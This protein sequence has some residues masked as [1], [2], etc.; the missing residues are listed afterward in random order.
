ML[1]QHPPFDAQTDPRTGNEV[2]PNK[3]RLNAAQKERRRALIVPRQRGAWGMLL[4]LVCEHF[5][6]ALAA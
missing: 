6:E 4:V 3:S 1:A 5:V 2:R